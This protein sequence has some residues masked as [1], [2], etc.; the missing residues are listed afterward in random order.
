MN[1]SGSSLN[2]IKRRVKYQ[3][4]G[5]KRVECW[6]KVDNG[7]TQGCSEAPQ[8]ERR[9]DLLDYGGSCLCPAEEKIKLRLNL[10]RLHGIYPLQGKRM[11]W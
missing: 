2:T 3:R 9:S 7:G 1:T 4:C 5:S 11:G 10:H 6:P 8:V